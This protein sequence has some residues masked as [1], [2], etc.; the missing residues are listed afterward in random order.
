MV[1]ASAGRDRRCARHHRRR[2][3]GRA[4]QAARPHRP[5]LSVSP[6]HEPR[7]TE[8]AFQ[9]TQRPSPQY[10]NIRHRLLPDGKVENLNLNPDMNEIIRGGGYET[11]HYVD[12]TGDGWVA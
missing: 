12:G 1:P 2:P 3:E 4:H 10:L 5:Q 8:D 9:E 11:L 7:F 6:E